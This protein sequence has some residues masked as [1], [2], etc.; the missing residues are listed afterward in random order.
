M[1]PVFA[2][3]R[4]QLPYLSAVAAVFSSLLLIF[5]TTVKFERASPDA[6][7][8]ASGVPSPEA[9]F[10]LISKRRSVF[11]KDYDGTEVPR[12][13]LEMMLDAANWAPTHG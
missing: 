8:E 12:E 7:K 13:K 2:I 1:E 9:A 6:A 11:P 5:L 10:A 3:T 4:D